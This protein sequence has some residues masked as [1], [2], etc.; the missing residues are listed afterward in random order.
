MAYLSFIVLF[1]SLITFIYN[2]LTFTGQ[3]TC[4]SRNIDTKE[5]DFDMIFKS[6][7]S[8]VNDI[9]FYFSQGKDEN[10]NDINIVFCEISGNTISLL[11]ILNKR[12]MEETLTAH[13]HL[14]TDNPYQEIKYE[15][16]EITKV[17]G[18]FTIEGDMTF[19]VI[20]CSV[21]SS[22]I[23]TIPL[24]TI[25]T[26]TNIKSIIP[27]TI[28]KSSLPTNPL[29]ITTIPK[30][31]IQ[32]TIPNTIIISTIPKTLIISTIPNTNIKSTIPNTLIISTIPNTNI[33]STLIKSIIPSN[34]ITN[35]FISTIS[36]KTS[37]IS[38][39]MKT[40]S[41]FTTIP[42]SIKKT[43]IEIITTTPT[44]IPGNNTNS[45]SAI[46]IINKSS[47]NLSAGVIAAIA[48]PCLA[49]L[50]AVALVA[51]LLRRSK[52]NAG[53]AP[54]FES[55]IPSPSFTDTSSLTKMNIPQKIEKPVQTPQII[56]SQEIQPAQ[57][58]KTDVQPI[59]QPQPVQVVPVQQVQMVP[60]QQVQAVPVQ[61]VQVVPVQEVQ[62]VP[63][64]EVQ[65]V[66]VEQVEMVPV[67]EITTVTEVAPQITH[68]KN[69]TSGT[70]FLS[71]NP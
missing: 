19:S 13:C 27:S 22:I 18:D 47:G 1:I 42:N 36:K 66:P 8:I 14:D 49:A 29:I 44:T 23:K 56:R 68:V 7:A 65:T 51:C 71:E 30:T 37:L 70:E 40:I 53:V 46:P 10:G 39:I 9:I 21:G 26:S 12:K 63:V 64:Q 61:E 52:A 5:N 69:V 15:N 17:S 41:V 48:I 59:I 62:M 38:T 2:Q 57:V 3:S 54:P 45:S 58:V 34:T 20:D 31:N 4:S 32:S 35:S 55:T 33:K 11:R 24:T 67:Q 43:N 28:F 25:K 6:D 60:V 50:L 16:P